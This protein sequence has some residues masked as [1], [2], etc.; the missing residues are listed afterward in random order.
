MKK[1]KQD[2]K[3]EAEWTGKEE[4]EIH[5]SGLSMQGCILYKENL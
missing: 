1:W 3:N 5:G 2:W 4:L